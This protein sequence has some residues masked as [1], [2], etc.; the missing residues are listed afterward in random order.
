MLVGV[1]GCG[2]SLFAKATA[3]AW[4]VPLLKLDLGALKSK[5]VGDSEANLR[6]V[7]K[8]VEAIGRCVVW[9]DEIEKALGRCHQRFGR[10]RRVLGR[11]RRAAELDAGAAR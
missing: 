10:R 7:F 11:A 2:K 6:K 3:T 8:L 4:E 1:P 5:F 9:I